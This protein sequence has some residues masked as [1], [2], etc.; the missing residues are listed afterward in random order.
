MNKKVTHSSQLKLSGT[1]VLFSSVRPVLVR[2]SM[3]CLL[4]KVPI[5]SAV[6]DHFYKLLQAICDE[7]ES[8]SMVLTLYPIETERK[9]MSD[10]YMIQAEL[11]FKLHFINSMVDEK[12]SRADGGLQGSGSLYMCDLCKA[13]HETAKT[14]LG[15]FLICRRLQETR[16]S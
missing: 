16:N 2:T 11:K 7:N 10:L 12:R 6:T 14:E 5:V 1:L 13:T 3:N 8:S 4:K 9:L 15:T